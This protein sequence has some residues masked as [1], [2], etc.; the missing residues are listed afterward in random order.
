M[1]ATRCTLPLWLTCRH[2]PKYCGTPCAR[3]GRSDRCRSAFSARGAPRNS[4][5]T[6][7]RALHASFWNALVKGSHRLVHAPVLGLP[8]T[9][10]RRLGRTATSRHDHQRQHHGLGSRSKRYSLCTSAKIDTVLMR[11]F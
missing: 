8:H 7:L 1:C 6:Q 3:F 5:S 9:G 2:A 4:H 11:E 10:A